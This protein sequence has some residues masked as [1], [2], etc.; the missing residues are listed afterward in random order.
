MGPEDR[1]WLSQNKLSNAADLVKDYLQAL[2]ALGRSA[3]RVGRASTNV[4]AAVSTPSQ[5]GVRTPTQA[6]VSTP[7]PSGKAT[8]K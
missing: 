3:P 1:E 8:S 2:Q 6:G 4:P 5:A 7:T